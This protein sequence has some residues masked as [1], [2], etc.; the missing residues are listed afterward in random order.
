MRISGHPVELALWFLAL[1]FLLRL[2]A[3]ALRR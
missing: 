2:A 3:R 1:A